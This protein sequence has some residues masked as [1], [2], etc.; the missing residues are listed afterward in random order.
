MTDVLTPEQRKLNMSRIRNKD[1]RPEVFV[2]SLVCKMGYRYKLNVRH[3]PGKPDLVL[4]KHRKIIV[5]H[6]CF[7]HMHKCKYG[8]AK[9][10]THAQFWQSKRVGNVKRDRQNLS[11][12]RKDGWKILVVWECWTRK[13]KLL[14]QR[15][16]KFLE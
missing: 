7:W 1:T 2:R 15:I 6:G 4:S 10:Q 13:P 8:K 5:V 12:L 3:L 11:L 14:E 16:S 9:P